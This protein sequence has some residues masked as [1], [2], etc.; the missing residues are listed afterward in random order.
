MRAIG[1][2]AFRGQFQAFINGACELM[3]GLRRECWSG[4]GQSSTIW[5]SYNESASTFIYQAGFG[6]GRDCG[7]AF[8]HAPPLQE[9]GD[10]LTR[11]IRNRIQT[12]DDKKICICWCIVLVVCVCVRACVY[13]RISM[14]EGINAWVTDPRA[15][16]LNSN[17][18]QS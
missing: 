18:I 14:R 6:F 11:R 17:I 16:P 8:D 1:A 7:C 5:Y 15:Q 13:L 4:V 3:C 10:M 12:R 9:F 2:V